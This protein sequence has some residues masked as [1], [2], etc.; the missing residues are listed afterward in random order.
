[1]RTLGPRTLLAIALVLLTWNPSGWSFVDWALRDAAALDAVKAFFGVVLLAGWV[2]CLRAA[3]VSLGALGI[4]LVAALIGTLVWMLV[5][6]GVVQPDNR[7][8]LVWLALVAVGIVLGVGVSWAKLRQR[9]S[10]EIETN[11]EP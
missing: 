7:R 5:Q 4:L 2:F 6:F 8:A 1:M 3:W 11:P 9:A 10:G